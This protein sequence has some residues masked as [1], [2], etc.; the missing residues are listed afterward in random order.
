MGV[1]LRK[2]R[3]KAGRDIASPQKAKGNCCIRETKDKEDKEDK[4]KT[5]GQRDSTLQWGHPAEIRRGVPQKVT[6]TF[7]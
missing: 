3:V 2:R 6:G 1:K 4:G 5:R 7:F